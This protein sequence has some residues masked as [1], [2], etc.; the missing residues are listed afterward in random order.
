MSRRTPTKS[1]LQRKNAALR[2]A[3]TKLVGLLRSQS[4]VARYDSLRPDPLRRPLEYRV[5]PTETEQQFAAW[6]RIKAYLQCDELYDNSPIGPTLQTAIRLAVGTRGGTPLFRGEGADAYQAAFDAWRPHAGYEEGDTLQD[7]LQRILHMVRIHGDCLVLCN[8]LS[9]WR[10]R[11]WDADQICN[12]ADWDGM[13]RDLGLPEDTRQVEGVCIDASGKVLGYTV[14]MLRNQ[15]GVD[16]RDATFLPA[17]ICRRVAYRRKHTQ[18]RGEPAFLLNEQISDMTK[19]LL[20]SELGAA[21]LASEMALVVVQPPGQAANEALAGIIEGFGQEGG[22]DGLAKDAGLSDDDLAALTEAAKPP[23]TFEAFQGRSSV[24]T[25]ANGTQVQNLQNSNRPSQPIQSWL[26]MLND[27]NGRALGLMSCL[28]RG[29]ADNSYSSAMVELNVSWAA[30]RQD[31]ALLE[32]QVVDY[33]VGQMFGADADYECYWDSAFSVDPE[34]TEKTLDMQLHG[35]RTTFREILGPGW[36][37]HLRQLAREKALIE[38]LG[39]TNLSFYETASGAPIEGAVQ[40]QPG[41]E[42]P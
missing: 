25:V 35:G 10:V 21:K 36:E 31:Q 18:Y 17:S 37:Q 24:A 39:L 6:Y 22:A 34:K 8:E 42:T 30:I 11:L 4:L 26:D 33:I 1:T 28:S 2:T 20:K 7:V 38:Q 12:V 15:Y 9:D 5:D 16:N 23:Q 14:T 32:R 27:A 41:E 29:R 13:A 40:A 19:E 3:A